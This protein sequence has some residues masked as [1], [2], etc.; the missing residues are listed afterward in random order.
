MLSIETDFS[1]LSSWDVSPTN[2]CYIFFDT[3]FIN[4]S[5]A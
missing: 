2:N 5:A 3:K 4:V 1:L